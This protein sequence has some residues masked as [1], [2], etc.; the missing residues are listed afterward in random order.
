[1]GKRGSEIVLVFAFLVVLI[2]LLAGCNQ[3]EKTVKVK[4]KNVVKAVFVDKAP[5]LDGKS[6]DAVWTKAPESVITLKGGTD[7]RIKS[8]YTQKMIYFLVSWDDTTPQSGV[9]W[10]EYNGTEWHR[11]Y[12][13]DDKVSFIWNIDHSLP[14]FDTKGCEAI[15]HQL[16]D[17]DQASM[18]ITGNK[19]NGKPW[20][21][22]DWKGDA[23]KW[24][25]GIMNEKNIV[26]DGIFAAPSEARK[27]PELTTVV[28]S[29]LIFDG[30]DSGTK[31]WFTRNPNAATEEEKAQDIEKPAYMPK[32]GYDLSKNPFPNQ[33]DMI[34]ITDYSV[35]KAGDKLPMMLY[36]DFTSEKNIKDFPEGKPTGSRVDLSGKGVY[37]ETTYTL[38]FGRKLNTGHDDDVQFHPEADRT[39]ADNIFAVAIFNDSRFKHAISGPVTLILEP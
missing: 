25:P 20:P 10:W 28:E 30:G 13:T 39:V 6:N 4:T 23:W 24:A 9:L 11:N 29:R 8:V 5:E 31:Q 15:C 21:G 7:A 3:R 26:D 17:S 32:L 12:D 34:P 36:F 1:V 35:F 19:T 2:V 38:E 18:T 16:P 14:L 27:R 33:R 37:A 22:I